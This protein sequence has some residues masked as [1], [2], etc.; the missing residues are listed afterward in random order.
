M[1]KILQLRIYRDSGGIMKLKDISDIHSGYIT[2]GKIEASVDGS[3]Y[4]L[5]AKDVD[6]EHLSYRADDLI[7]FNPTLSRTDRC[8]EKG[9]LLFMARGAHNFT[10]LLGELPEP[11]V[12]AACFFI[13]RIYHPQVFPGY[14]CWYLNQAPVERYLVQYSGRGVHMPVVRRAVLENIQVP[15]PAMATQRK[16]ADMNTLML[17][18]MD[19]LQQLGKKRRELIAAGCLQVARER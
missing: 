8:L 17:K 15:L 7:R 19:L 3:H 5:Q 13:V 11:T 16:I 9:D 10:I 18:E 12:A 14:L 1:N 4:L 2:R 6:A